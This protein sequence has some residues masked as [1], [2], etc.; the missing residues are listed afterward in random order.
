MVFTVPAALYLNRA[1]GVHAGAIFRKVLQAETFFCC[2]TKLV[3]M[4]PNPETHVHTA[5]WICHNTRAKSV[6][7]VVQTLRGE[8]F[9][10]FNEYLHLN[11]GEKGKCLL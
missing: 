2:I 11:W 3:Q 10:P 8:R 6:V 7:E 1:S 9:A 5:V 4:F